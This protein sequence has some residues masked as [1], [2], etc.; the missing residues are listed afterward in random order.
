MDLARARKVRVP[1]LLRAL[2]WS[3]A[4]V[5]GDAALASP[6]AAI[7]AGSQAASQASAGIETTAD[8]SNAKVFTSAT[9]AVSSHTDFT[10]A[11]SKDG[12]VFAWGWDTR[13]QLGRGRKLFSAV[14]VK[15]TGLPV[16]AHMDAG[17]V[18]VAAADTAGNVWTWGQDT[19]GQLGPRETGEWTRPGRVTGVGSVRRVVAAFSF[20][21]AL[22]NDGT[23]SVWGSFAQQGG[24]PRTIAGLTG[25]SEIRGGTGHL[26]AL[27]KNNGTVWTVGDNSAGQLGDGTAGN[28]RTSAF[29][30]P[31]LA[32]IVKIA[33]GA[34]SS[35]ALRNDGTV[36]AWGEAACGYP[37][38]P[39]YSPQAVSGLAGVADISG[40]FH[41]SHAILT[42]GNVQYWDNNYVPAVRSEFSNVAQ[43]FA[44]SVFESIVLSKTGT[45][46]VF[47]N[48]ELGQHGLGNT[49]PTPVVTTVP[50]WW[51]PISAFM[52]RIG[53]SS[54]S[55]VRCSPSPLQPLELAV[56]KSQMIPAGPLERSTSMV[57]SAISRSAWS[58]EIR[59]HLPSP[60]SPARVSGYRS[61][62]ASYMRWL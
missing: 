14:P 12:K 58:Q 52:S 26:V 25:I 60:R 9:P 56:P 59:F 19:L 42:N 45:V 1:P 39:R 61:R 41:Y 22:R 46:Q 37:S 48:N 5:T 34:C 24:A 18:H 36:F 43:L 2:F 40:G 23:V 53:V 55:P 28:T 44:E 33:A 7:D 32:N 6:G 8:S 35:L 15:I 47:G 3:A 38:T 29:Q 31:G 51:S 21:A 10:L 50:G 11:L 49:L 17:P 20:T 57:W 13:G 16:L 27:N 54:T 4:L 30:V 62:P